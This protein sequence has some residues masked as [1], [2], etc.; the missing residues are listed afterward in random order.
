MVFIMAPGK[1]DTYVRKKNV[2]H[3]CS[4]R[5]QSPYGPHGHIYGNEKTEGRTEDGGVVQLDY[6]ICRSPRTC[7]ER[8][9]SRAGPLPVN[10]GHNKQQEVS[11]MNSPLEQPLYE[12][13][14][15]EESSSYQ[16]FRE[17]SSWRKRFR[18]P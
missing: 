16:T 4:G 1:T 13:P 14:R 17:R 15:W 18:H 12:A 7:E 11:S 9:S 5:T 2:P 8:G 6:S 10:L 3:F